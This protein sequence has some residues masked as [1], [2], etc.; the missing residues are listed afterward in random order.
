LV[1]LSALECLPIKIG[2]LRKFQSGK[3]EQDFQA[4]AS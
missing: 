1:K 4:R 2:W 3:I